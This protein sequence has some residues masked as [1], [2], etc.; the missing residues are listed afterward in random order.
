M[1]HALRNLRSD[2]SCARWARTFSPQTA[3]AATERDACVSCHLSS[4]LTI[5]KEGIHFLPLRPRAAGLRRKTFWGSSHTPPLVRI[6]TGMPLRAGAAWDCAV[7]AGKIHIWC[8]SLLCKLSK[9]L[10]TSHVG[11]VEPD[12]LAPHRALPFFIFESTTN[13][14]LI[15][16][17]S[18]IA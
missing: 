1:L 7:L 8:N 13:L 6:A 16:T 17:N 15:Y 10:D 9:Q 4:S 3:P 18:I 12:L 2:V 5:P 14:M 11:L